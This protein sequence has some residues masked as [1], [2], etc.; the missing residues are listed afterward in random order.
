MTQL[1]FIHEYVPSSSGTDAY[2]L[3]LLHG[4]GGNEQDLIPLGRFL[5]DDAALL[6][7]R[8]KVLEGGMP[9]FFRRLAEGVFDQEDLL[10]RTDELA[11]FLRAASETYGIHPGKRIAVGY[12]N[13]ANIAA[14]IL[15]RHP[16]IFAGALLFRPMV[17][18]E[19]TDATGT[20]PLRDKPVLLSAG[21]VDPLI[22]QA[23]TNRLAEL[24]KVQGAAVELHF[25]PGGHG[26]MQPELQVAKAWYEQN[27]GR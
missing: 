3:V 16:D 15:L 11:D 6:G 2:T 27:F 12:S 20:Q 18:F 9:R 4:T 19:P 5:A 10:F 7:V 24:L 26:L 17:P 23:E 8:G 21:E 25:N 14:S 13:G 22:P 1:D